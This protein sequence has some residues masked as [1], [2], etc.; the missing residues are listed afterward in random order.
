VGPKETEKSTAAGKAERNGVVFGKKK[1]TG[2]SFTMQGTPKRRIMS[3]RVPEEDGKRE[4]QTLEGGDLK[5]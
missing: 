5:L 3:N 2:N 1:V 4:V